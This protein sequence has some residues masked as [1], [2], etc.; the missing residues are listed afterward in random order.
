MRAER[1]AALRGRLPAVLAAL[2]GLLLHAASALAAGGFAGKTLI[3]ALEEL[4]ALGLPVVYST[5]VVRPELRVEVEPRAREPELALREMLAPHGL[6]VA[7]GP[8]GRLLIVPAG[9]ADARAARLGTVAG[10][11]TD[12]RDRPLAGVTV[13]LAGLGRETRTGAG[14]RF[15]LTDVPE[16]THRVEV[17]LPASTATL[18]AVVTVTAGDTA[19]VTFRLPEISIPIDEIVVVSRLSMLGDEP[20]TGVGFDRERIDALPHFG[21]DLYRAI[22]A[23]PGVSNDDFTAGFNVR[24]G[25]HDE[26]LVRLDG[27]ELYEPFHLQD[28]KGLFSIVDPRMVGDL[29]LLPGAFPAEFGDRSSAVLDIRTARPSGSS[30]HLE[31]SF[32]GASAGA[33]GLF[34]DGR[35]RWL[36]SARRG[37]LDLILD[38][39]ES[40]EDRGEH[41][42]DLTYWDL[43][44]KLE[45]DVDERNSLALEVL[46]AG[47]TVSFRELEVDDFTKFDTRWRN[48]YVWLEHRAYVGDRAFAETA[49]SVGRVDHDREGLT[50]DDT[51]RFGIE[52]RREVDFRGLRQDWNLSPSPRYLLKG[53]LEVRSFE[54]V[55][56][57]HDEI[58]RIDGIDDPRFEPVVDVTRFRG[59]RTGEHYAAYLAG[60][61][62][63]GPRLVVEAGTRYDRQTLTGED[64]VSPRLNLVYDLGRGGRLRMGWGHF[65]Q[66]QRP[67]ELEVQYGEESYQQAQR[68]EHF[69]L[70]WEVELPRRSAL[71]LEAYR[72]RVSTPQRRYETLF[73]PFEP[74]PQAALDLVVVAPRRV[75]SEG[76]EATL[77][78][79]PGDR[80][81]WW[82]TYVYSSI[83]DEIDGRD[84]PRWYDQPHALTLG[85]SFRPGR[86]WTLTGVARYHT[87]WP[88]T[89][90]TA[91]SEGGVLTYQVGPFYADRLD[92]YLSLD[93]RVSRTARLRRGELTAFLDV[94]NLLDRDNA[95]GLAIEDATFVPGPDGTDVRFTELDWLGVLPSLGLSWRF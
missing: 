49:L 76:V 85:A 91:T 30:R 17:T 9:S 79:R 67:H 51:D 4:R 1:P 68:A 83:E 48:G 74:V 36:G 19:E 28:F 5:A 16:G 2:A 86:V 89:R 53:G 46:V 87:G 11:V 54:T 59:R 95:R 77:R 57:Y 58:D 44:G 41:Q 15:E 32:S 3:E 69:N 78:G 6:D 82:I 60:R 71:R 20:A 34:D 66:S 10:R 31:V 21:D 56:D 29:E 42:P 81:D 94:Q 37:Y 70:G 12:E 23:L 43:F 25:A 64:Q 40:D 50:F 22:N 63:V 24:G 18:D 88:T 14:G 65:F 84:V 62:P 93:L 26:V 38:L 45:Y 8:Q 7:P 92:D 90:V 35:G 55:F 73:D 72:R 80:F 52:D 13:A 47:D 61:L 33:A 27:L 39:A 75:V